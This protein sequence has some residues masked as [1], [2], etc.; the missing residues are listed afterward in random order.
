[1]TASQELAELSEE[2]AFEHVAAGALRSSAPGVVGLELEAHLVDLDNPV[3]RVEWRRAELA[4]T[5]LAGRCRSRVTLE[6]GGQLEL[7]GLPAPDV[8]AAVRDMRAD[9]ALAARELAHLGLGLAR[10]GADPVRSPGILS[11][12]PRYAAMEAHFA[13]TGQG[14]AGVRM[15]SDSASVQVNLEAGLEADWSTRVERAHRLGPVLLSVSGCSALTERGDTGWVSS[16]QRLWG[17]LDASRCG[18]LVHSEQPAHAWANY[19]LDAPVMLVHDTADPSWQA[20][21]PVLGRVLFRQWATGEVLLG[22][23][24]PTRADL[25]YHLTTLFPP[26]RLRGFLE[27]RYLDATPAAWWPAIA[28]LTTL[29]MDD[30]RAAAVADEACEPVAQHWAVAAHHGLGDPDLARAARSCTAV[31]LEVCPPE[32]RADLERLAELVGTGRCPGDLVLERA[33]AHGAVAVLLESMEVL[34]A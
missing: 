29:L 10:L 30:P 34:D 5:T 23:R 12:A 3:G 31:A 25:D 26:V 18:P 9:T 27:L 21:T 33:A 6:P 4:M 28:T 32:L 24:P 8:V 7:S 17:A 11:P 1:M 13:A 20:V 16:R 22:D 15:M 2:A 14:E 19:A